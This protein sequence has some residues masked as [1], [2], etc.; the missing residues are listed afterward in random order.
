MTEAIET[1]ST[2]GRETRVDAVKRERRNRDSSTLDKMTG[3]KLDIFSESQLDK[4]NYVYRW[5]NDDGTGAR[6]QQAYNNDYD[7]VGG[8]DIKNYNP[9]S[10]SSESDERI[11]MVVGRDAFGSASYSYLMKKPRE[12]F[13][14]DQEEMVERREDT[15]RGIVHRGDVGE[16]NG[17]TDRNLSESSNIYAAGDNIIGSAGARRNGPINKK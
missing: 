1:K 6:I 14:E 17:I 4:E 5:V 15:M 8:S 3:M 2:R 10:T 11:R 16:L 13:E 12:F 9:L 7:F